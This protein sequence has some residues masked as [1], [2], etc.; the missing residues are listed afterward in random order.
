MA[1]RRRGR[2]EG[3]IYPRSDGRWV[4]AVSLGSGK[5]KSVYGKTAAEAREKMRK[6]QQ[7]I[8]SGMLPDTESLTVAAFSHSFLE[9]TEPTVKESTLRRYEQLLR[10][11]V[12]PHIGSRRLSSIKARRS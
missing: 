6:V 4:G 7:Q 9:S 5:R 12:I 2:G 3:S 8:E 10:V 11:H 1:N